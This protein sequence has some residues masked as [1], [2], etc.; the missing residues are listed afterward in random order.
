MFW[1]A[2]VIHSFYWLSNIPLYGYTTDCFLFL[3]VVNNA[4]V[5]I[6]VYTFVWTCV[7]ISPGYTPKGGTGSSY[8]DSV[9]NPLVHVCMLS[10]FSR[11]SSLQLCKALQSSMDCSLCPW[12][13]PGK[14]TG[15]GC[16]A[17]SLI[18]WR[19]H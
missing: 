1:H 13:F 16:H 14:K 15:V 11:C 6:H 3:A 4:A 18:H 9:C 19:N 12:D 10:S 7:F 2:S 8:G 5:N 17:S